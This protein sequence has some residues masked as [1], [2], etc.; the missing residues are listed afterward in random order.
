[1]SEAALNK[2]TDFLM[3]FFFF[4]GSTSA[5]TQGLHLQPLHQPF[6][7]LVMDF[8]QDSV[9]GIICPGWLPTVILLISAS[10]VAGVTG[11]GAALKFI[12]FDCDKIHN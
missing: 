12:I 2:K 9:L 8:F 7:F 6:F 5:C 3:Y 10:W 1:M 4:F 11:V